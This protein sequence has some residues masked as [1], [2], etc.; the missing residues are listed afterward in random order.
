MADVF[1]SFSSKDAKRVERI[2]ARLVERG[3]EVWWMRNL[4]PGD[5]PIKT[6]SR[7][8]VSAR[9]VLLAWRRSPSMRGTGMSGIC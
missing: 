8:L 6:V 9:N 4:L 7:E 2:H 3:F 5:S 1:I